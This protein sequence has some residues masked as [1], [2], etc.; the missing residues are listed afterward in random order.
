MY[1]LSH[2]SDVRLE[3]SFFLIK[4]IF[5]FVNLKVQNI[6]RRYK[7]RGF[8]AIENRNEK[9]NDASSLPSVI[10]KKIE[11]Q[12]IFHRNIKTNEK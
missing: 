5:L 9:R 8:I 3:K 11:K 4:N 6:L 7:E 2:K 1:V 12:Y 10:N